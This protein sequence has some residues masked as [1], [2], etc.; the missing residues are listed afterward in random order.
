KVDT[1]WC[2]SWYWLTPGL[3]ELVTLVKTEVTSI[4]IP[5]QSESSLGHW[6]RRSE[7]GSQR[8]EVRGQRS[9]IGGQSSEIRGQR[10]ETRDR[11]SEIRNQIQK[12]ERET[13][14]NLHSPFKFDD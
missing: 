3:T 1:F 14:N 4:R 9:E 11:R 2:F 7:I 5:A 8:S 10:S 6:D 13:R 12:P